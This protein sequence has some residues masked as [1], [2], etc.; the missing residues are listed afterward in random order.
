MLQF[1]DTLLV[2]VNLDGYVVACVSK[3]QKRTRFGSL[4]VSTKALVDIKSGSAASLH[5]RSAS[6]TR[7][8]N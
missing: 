3:E 1:D 7:R 4:T 6:L 2:R 5:L 8:H